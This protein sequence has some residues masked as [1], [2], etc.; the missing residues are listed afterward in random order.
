MP[1][2]F[3]ELPRNRS[4]RI[5]VE[6][7]PIEPVPEEYAGDNNP[8]RGIETHGVAPT[9]RPSPV[10]KFTSG[11]E[12][13]YLDEVREPEPVPVRIVQ[14]GPEFKRTFRV[15]GH[16]YNY[17]D[18]GGRPFRLLPREP[19]RVKVTIIATNGLFEMYI[20]ASDQLKD[21]SGGYPISRGRSVSIETTVVICPLIADSSATNMRVAFIAEYQIPVRE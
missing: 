3:V 12:V 6:R 21:W 18:F 15:D 7:E 13:E 4:R 11:V 19:Y 17:S 2:P 20:G 5:D 10:P 1:N 8:Y 16:Q 14:S 9:E